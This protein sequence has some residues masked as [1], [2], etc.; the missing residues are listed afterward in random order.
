MIRLL[1]CL[2]LTVLVAACAER[3]DATAPELTVPVYMLEGAAGGAHA[4]A[5]F[6][7]HATGD[8][9][10]PPNDSRARGQATFRLENAGTELHYRLIVSNIENVSM[11]HIHLAPAGVNGPVG[12]WLYPGAPPPQLIAG[13]VNGVLAEGVITADN[14]V[15]PLA[16]L[17]MAD[18]VEIMQAGG[19]YVNVH[20]SQYPGGEVRGL[21]R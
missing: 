12:V 20:T 3:S 19:A 8:Q 21:I 10:V 5:M 17:S 16:G 15:G 13:R 11:A 2:I 7:A 4:P 6:H 9:E 1:S 14:F 18:L